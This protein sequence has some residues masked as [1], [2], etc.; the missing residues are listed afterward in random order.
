MIFC[1]PRIIGAFIEREVNHGRR[2]E[3]MGCSPPF[4]DKARSF[5]PAATLNDGQ[6]NA[7]LNNAG[8][9]GVASKASGL[10]DVELG[11]GRSSTPAPR[12][13]PRTQFSTLQL[14]SNV[15]HLGRF[16]DLRLSLPFHRSHG[17]SL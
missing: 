14:R 15:C 5:V 12:P 1:P 8:A 10:V 16:R 3:A 6:L 11:H 17:G 9:D 2:V 7:A 4:G 13:L